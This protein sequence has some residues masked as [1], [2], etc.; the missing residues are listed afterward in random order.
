MASAA[1]RFLFDAI[2][3]PFE[4]ELHHVF[5]GRRFC[6]T[7]FRTG[8]YGPTDTPCGI[9]FHML[10]HA[11]TA[12]LVLALVSPAVRSLSAQNPAPT[13]PLGWNSWDS[14]G[15]TIDEADYRANT[16]VLAGMHQYGWDYSVIDEGWYMQDPFAESVEA[17]K[18]IWDENGILIPDGKRFPS[19]VMGAGFKPMADWVHSQGLKF[20]VHIVRGIPRQVVDGNLPIAG[21]ITTPRMPPT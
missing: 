10:R 2:I 8:W 14:Y 7:Q 3:G 18:Y 19:S 21:T 11:L 20:G 6:R 9:R 17:R 1:V 15:L 13:P 4:S 12:A 5:L 16:K